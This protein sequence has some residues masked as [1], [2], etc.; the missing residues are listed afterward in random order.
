MYVW[1]ESKQEI[2]LE[3]LIRKIKIRFPSREQKYIKNKP[4]KFALFISKENVLL[5]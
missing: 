5:L 1:Y 4:G 2:S 3:I